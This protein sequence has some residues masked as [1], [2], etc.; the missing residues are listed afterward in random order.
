VRAA[1]AQRPPVRNNAN[2]MERGIESGTGV[3]VWFN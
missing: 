2:S 3:G 1:N